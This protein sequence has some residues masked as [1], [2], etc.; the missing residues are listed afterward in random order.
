MGGDEFT[1]LLVGQQSR[2]APAL[3][4]AMVAC[5]RLPIVNAAFTAQLGA[6]AGICFSSDFSGSAATQ[7]YK[8][9]DYALFE[10]KR[11]GKGRSVT[12]NAKHEQSL[13]RESQIAHLLRTADLECELTP[14]FQPIVDA[15]TFSIRA[16]EALARWTSPQLGL[17]APQEFIPVAER[18]D[19]IFGISQL[20]LRA[21]LTWA[22]AWPD[23]VLLKVNLSV[24][25]L[26]SSE[27]TSSLLAILRQ[28]GVKTSRVTFE[29]TETIL[30]ESLEQIRSNV[31]VVRGA[32]CKIA[33][34]DFG[35]GYSSLN[36]IHM[37]APDMI[38]IDKCF[39]DNIVANETTRRVVRT[40]IE[41]ARNV[42]AVS[43]AEGGRDE[44]AGAASRRARLQRAAGLLHLAARQ[45]PGEYRDGMPRRRSWS[46]GTC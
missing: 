45:R 46:G 34:D 44:G 10:A 19:L 35:V 1:C 4:E 21:A 17:V 14:V 6:S 31:D 30:A 20:M 18:T 24:R 23:A 28:S 29:I 40:I 33:V 3:A 11:S 8:H 5:C 39:V 42:G 36:Y 27:Q 26:M 32:G 41:L 7:T 43:V 15:E 13:Q 22:A 2:D 37:L 16:F 9:A 38:K 12:F 25:D